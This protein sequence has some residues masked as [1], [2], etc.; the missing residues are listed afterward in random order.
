MPE[1]IGPR[2]VTT[3]AVAL[4]ALLTVATA[5]CAFSKP[6]NYR[7]GADEAWWQAHR[8]VVY[9]LMMTAEAVAQPVADV[10]GYED[11]C[12]TLGQTVEEAQKL[13]HFPS[14]KLDVAWQRALD[15][16]SDSVSNCAQ[17]FTSGVRLNSVDQATTYR[18]AAMNYASYGQVR[19]R[20]L[21]SLF[22]DPVNG[23]PTMATTTTTTTT[24]VA[25]PTSPAPSTTPAP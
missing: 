3:L 10:P 20:T 11:K 17:S 16:F 15:L 21:L 12:K 9:E 7:G 13:P 19:L 24:T 5:G 14:K 4:L 25:A 8:Q 1:P 2:R 22:G 23:P 18:L 6:P